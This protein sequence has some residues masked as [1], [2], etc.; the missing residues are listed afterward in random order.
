MRL[1]IIDYVANPGGGIKF[2]SEL[3]KSILS[4]DNSFNIT[5]VSCGE[6]LE[7]YRLYFS[8]IQQKHW[9]LVMPRQKQK[10]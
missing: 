1:R 7:N 4:L 6:A 8:K 3:I 9:D 5:I 2:S 10:Q